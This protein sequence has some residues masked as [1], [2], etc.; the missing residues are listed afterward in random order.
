MGNDSNINNINVMSNEYFYMIN[1]RDDIYFKVKV[2]VY[3]GFLE[4]IILCLVIILFY[5]FY[6]FNIKLNLNVK[7]YYF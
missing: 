5:W 1:L 2:L 4:N 6:D 3:F 7:K